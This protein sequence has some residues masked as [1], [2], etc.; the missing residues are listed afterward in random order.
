MNQRLIAEI[1]KSQRLAI[2]NHLKRTQGLSVNELSARLKMSYMGV[3]QHCVELEKGRYIDRWRR[4][5]QVGRPEVV[6]RLT[7][8]A[9]EL[10]PTTSNKATIELLEAAGQLYGPSAPEKLLFRVF[11]EKAKTYLSKLKGETLA[12]RAR[13]LARLRD[14]DGHMSEFEN[15][16]GLLI[17]EHHSPI[18]DLLLAF[19]IV[20][21]LEAEMF[22][23][24]LGAAVE[25]EEEN[26]SGLFRCTFHIDAGG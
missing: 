14:H 2:V 10:F 26:V 13:W 16:D 7:S 23:R 6:Y 24:V 19:P 20:A 11:Q 1:G 9:H 5:K 18:R 3:K 15:Q 25:R 12:T 17:V 4:P 22:S 8:R 21:R